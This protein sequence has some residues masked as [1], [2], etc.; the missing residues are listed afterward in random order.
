[1]NAPISRVLSIKKGKSRLQ[2]HPDEVILTQFLQ[3]AKGTDP[4]WNANTPIEKW[5]SVM[6][7]E[8]GRVVRLFWHGLGLRGN[9]SYRF[10]PDTL[11]YIDLRS[12][13][14][15]G[16]VDLSVFPQGLWSLALGHNRHTGELDFTHLPVA[17]RNLDL[18]YNR[19]CGRLILSDLPPRLGALNLRH[20]DFSSVLDVSSLSRR[21]AS[22]DLCSNPKLVIFPE[23]VLP[24]CVRTDETIGR[25]WKDIR[26]TC[27]LIF[28]VFLLFA[29][30]A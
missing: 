25:E 4:T 8:D 7:S 22:L 26:T 30:N 27:L 3:D 18:S 13:E 6:C 15:G 28:Y 19:F 24:R 20:N 17:L 23:H 1:M 9:L 5:G 21:L 14:L 2:L 29:L 12:N 11:A 10:L 16:T